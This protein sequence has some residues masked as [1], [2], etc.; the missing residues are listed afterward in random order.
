M[1]SGIDATDVSW[2]LGLLYF[3]KHIFMEIEIVSIFWLEKV[4]LF[5]KTI[6]INKSIERKILPP[7]FQFMFLAMLSINSIT[8]ILTLCM[9]WADA[10]RDVLFSKIILFCLFFKKI[11]PNQKI[12]KLKNIVFLP[13]E[14]LDERFILFLQN[15]M[16]SSYDLRLIQ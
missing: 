3:M 4:S 10:T 6:F 8:S 16:A 13:S 5:C 12:R 15:R 11:Q 7:C 2:K 14:G 9:C 1:F